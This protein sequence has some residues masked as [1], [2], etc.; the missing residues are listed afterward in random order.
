MARHEHAHEVLGLAIGVVA[1]DD[2]LV[3]VLVVE[4]ADRALDQRAFLVDQRRGGGAQR[5]LA[6]VLPQPQQIFEV[7]LDLGARAA[8]AGGPQDHAHA[9]RHLEVGD[10]LLQALAVGHRGDL[11]ADAAAARGIGHQHRIAAGER[12]V[13]GQR[14]ALVAALLLDDLDQQHLA[15]L[16]DFLD[17]VLAHARLAPL[18]H[19]FHRVLGADRFDPV[20]ADD[21]VARPR[22]PSRRLGASASSSARRRRPRRRPA[23]RRLRQSPQRLAAPADGS[24]GRRVARPASLIVGG[25]AA[26]AAIAPEVSSPPLVLFALGCGLGR[27]S[28]NLGLG[29]GCRRIAAS[30]PVLVDLA[31]LGLDQRL[32]VGDRDL[33]V[34]GMD[35]RKGEEAVAVAAVIDERRLQRR[36]DPR[37]LR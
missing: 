26:S 30:R 4:V 25:A 1:G 11:A 31:L 12:Q 13:G 6:H 19:L 3:D 8:G 27:S 37:D 7:A 16:D 2:D 21:L 29:L 35:F 9:F 20:V 10:D 33:V 5:Q 28:A 18:R 24:R 14:R 34:V 32:P 23:R 17:L 15:A 22:P 36:L